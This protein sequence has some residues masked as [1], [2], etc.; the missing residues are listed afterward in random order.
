MTTAEKNINP[1]L[2]ATI[3][4][5]LE[6]L[7]LKLKKGQPNYFQPPPEGS[8]FGLTLVPDATQMLVFGLGNPDKAKAFYTEEDRNTPGT[9]F[10]ILEKPLDPNINTISVAMHIK[11]GSEKFS[12]PAS[13]RT[14]LIKVAQLDLNLEP[15]LY[16]SAQLISPPNENEQVSH[17][18]TGLTFTGHHQV[19]EPQ[20]I[21]NGPNVFVST[22]FISQDPNG[23]LLAEKLTDLLGQETRVISQ[24]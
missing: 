2:Q 5:G 13:I 18:L 7:K 23:Q 17:S 11:K 16:V 12:Y 15:D 22:E 20:I 3:D 1:R 14:Q 8:K 4:K 10:G 21:I 9:V 24:S 19:L 6:K